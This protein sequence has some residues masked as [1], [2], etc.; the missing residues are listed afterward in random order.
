MTGPDAMAEVTA[1]ERPPALAEPVVPV[2]PRWIAL[3][4]IANL[5]VWMGFFTPIQVLLPEQLQAISPE[6][7][8]AL[9]G[10]VTGL[11]ALAA[12]ISNPLAGALSDRT[13]G[14][15]GRRRPW[16]LGGGVLGAVGLV[17]LSFQDNVV[18]VAVGWRH[19]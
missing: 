18:G 6:H 16:V 12:V 13:S 10:W 3:L 2:R 1:T 15:F 11:G 9:L 19:R 14:R 8:A 5:A 7:K 17:A 4:V